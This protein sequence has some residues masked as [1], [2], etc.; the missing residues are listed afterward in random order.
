MYIL[1]TIIVLLFTVMFF[2]VSSF[3]L[4]FD[5]MPEFIDAP[6]FIVLLLLCLFFLMVTGTLKDFKNAIK[7]TVKRKSGSHTLGEL[8]DAQDSVIMLSQAVVYSS[9]FIT[10]FCGV[11]I[12]YHMDD[13]WSIGPLLAI[14]LLSIVYGMFTEMVLLVMKMNLQ[15]KIR[16]YLEADAGDSASENDEELKNEGENSER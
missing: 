1:A 10:A 3:G 12:L 9:I 6:T 15:K 13:L 7:F 8:R 2:W 11:D 5:I 14:M 16:N 4:S